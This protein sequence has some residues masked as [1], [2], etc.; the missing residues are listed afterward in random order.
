MLDKFIAYLEE[1]VQNHSIYVW[2]AQGESGD[3]ITE[4]WIKKKEKTAANAKRAIA[5]WK[6]Q[7]E[8]GFA[9]VLRAFD[10]SG[11]AM[12]FL[13]NVEG[14]MKHDTTADGLMKQC[15]K[16]DRADVR[17]GDFVFRLD[18]ADKATHIG[19]VVDDALN[20]IEAKGRDHGVVKYGINQ[21]GADHWNGFG[22]PKFFAVEEP[23]AATQ[24]PEQQ[25][26]APQTPPA[27]G[28]FK[29]KRVLKVTKPL[30][31]GDDVKALQ[32]ALISRGFHCGTSGADGIFGLSTAQAVRHF[33][34][35]N[36][37]IVDGKAGRFT[38]TALGGKWE[39]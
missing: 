10:C 28:G 19:Y 25:P 8:A 39:G 7:C 30:V 26:P 4:E 24:E 17:R 5:F 12:Y 31:K 1:Q 16:I 22:R 35:M 14:V 32:K 34:S 33:Q 6:A 21:Q 36:R 15:D 13:Q 2:G 38:I 23:A 3:A 9:G 20:V 37:L 29:V 18:D 11:L 27:T